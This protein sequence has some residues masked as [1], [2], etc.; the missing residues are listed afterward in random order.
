MPEVELTGEK[1][2]IEVFQTSGDATVALAHTEGTVALEP[3]VDVLEAEVHDKMRKLRKPGKESVDLTFGALVTTTMPYL[4]MM[5]L[6][7]G[8]A[9][10]TLQFATRGDALFKVVVRVY[11]AAADASPDQTLTCLTCFAILEGI[12]WPGGSDFARCRL[13]FIVN[14]DV[15][16][17]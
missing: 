7:T 8:S 2:S 10:Q 1:I 9:P 17:A 3:S 11:K 16:L 5:G 12:E 6:A 13:R 4:A 14:G 15:T